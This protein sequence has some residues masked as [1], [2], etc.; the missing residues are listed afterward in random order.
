M[1]VPV[2]IRVV[3]AGRGPGEPDLSA[4]PRQRPPAPGRTL[5]PAGSSCPQPGPP[6]RALPPQPGRPRGRSP[7]THWLPHCTAPASMLRGRRGSGFHSGSGRC[8]AARSPP[9]TSRPAPPID[10]PRAH[11]RRRQPEGGGG[12]EDAR[13]ARPIQL[14][15]EGR[16]EA[17]VMGGRLVRSVKGAAAH[18]AGEL[19]RRQD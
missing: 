15:P 10:P 6:P 17:A 8:P 2:N 9:G 19:G 12:G 18:R 1:G 3:T 7:Q 11:G 13:Q 14:L 4:L 16:R 5:D